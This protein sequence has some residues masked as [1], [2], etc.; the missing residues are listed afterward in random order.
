VPLT[1]NDVKAELSYAYLH[2]VVSRAG[3]SCE[4]TGR[5]SDGAGV[6]AVLRIRER[7]TPPPSLLEF[8][9]DVQLKATSGEPVLRDDR[10]SFWLIR[11]HY[12]KLRMT[13]I[14]DPRILV[15]LFLPSEPSQWVEQ[16]VDAL[17]L[18]RCAL[19]VCLYDAPPTDNQTGQTVYLPR[20]N[21]F[22]VEGL[23]DMLARRA[24]GEMIRYVP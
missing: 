18:R 15:V 7:L 8:T 23:R 2:T 14:R 3:F 11:R 13:E 22:S 16:T 20:E 21:V 12:D 1:E 10:Y 19:W 9:V 6:D 17:L 24:T 5:L 4:V